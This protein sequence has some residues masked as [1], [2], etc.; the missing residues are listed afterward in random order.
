MPNWN[1]NWQN[2]RWDHAAAAAAIVALNRAA[3]EVDRLAGERAGAALVVLGE[4]RGGHREDFNEQLQR[5]AA[6]DRDLAA[7]LRRAAGELARLGQ[8]ARTEQARRERERDE[9][10]REC[11]REDRRAREEEARKRRASNAA[12]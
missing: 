2:V 8:Q 3:A 4:W 5:A 6:A 1:P 7:D 10:R 9:W 11:E 12:T